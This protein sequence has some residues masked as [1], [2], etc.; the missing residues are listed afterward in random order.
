M[1]IYNLCGT[2][3]GTYLKKIR[4]SVQGKIN[5]LKKNVF[6]KPLQEKITYLDYSNY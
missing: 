4:Y 2:H 3:C 6:Y 1:Q 5:Y